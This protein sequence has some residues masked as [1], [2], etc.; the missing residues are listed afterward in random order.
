MLPL[1]LAVKNRR[2][3]ISGPEFC[4]SD[5][6]AG[7]TL[8]PERT[9]VTGGPRGLTVKRRLT[10]GRHVS[11]SEKDTYTLAWVTE[12]AR[13]PRDEWNRLALPA[14]S[15]FLEWEWLALM[16]T[17]GSIV[18]EKGWQP[19]HL[20]VRRNDALVAVAPLYIK[21]HSIGEFVFDYAWADAAARM[22]IAYYP[23]L[24]GMSPVTPLSGY[25]FLVDPLV[26]EAAVTDMMFSIIERF[27]ETNHL[28]GCHLNFVDPDW[29]HH[30]ERNGY[31]TWCH[32]S[33][34]WTNRGYGD[35]ADYLARFNTNQ[36]K[37]IRKERW[38]MD[39]A[40]IRLECIPGTDLPGP[41]GRLMYDYYSRTNDKFGLWGCKYLTPEFFDSLPEAFS[42]S[43]LSSSNALESS[44]P[45]SL[46]SGPKATETFAHGEP[47]FPRTTAVACSA[48][49]AI[50][51]RIPFRPAI[52]NPPARQ[53][54]LRY[55]LSAPPHAK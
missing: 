28:S 31:A 36:R 19:C 24:V 20:T 27:C 3:A 1:Q 26:N 15:P 13:I 9:P 29:K 52:K 21:A 14:E 33:F 47:S 51:I 5:V 11:T 42:N 40:G 44:A 32:Q 6:W 46:V 16:E 49:R 12:L 8:H 37:N 43:P 23:K 7:R 34:Q 2:R 50:P 18:P 10:Q 4:L 25:R 17:S 30:A 41:Y 35:F 22:D 39:Q 53:P 45:G 48:P 38:S 54:R 55:S